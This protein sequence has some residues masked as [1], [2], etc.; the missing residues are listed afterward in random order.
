LKMILLAFLIYFLPMCHSHGRLMTPISRVGH[1]NY[2]NDPTGSSSNGGNN[3]DAWVCRHENPV[4]PTVAYDAGSTITLT[5]FFGAK[6]VGD[7]DV[8]LSYDF[9]QPRG[10][11][12]WFKVANFYDCK[13]NS[14]QQPMTLTLPSWL[15]SGKATLR[16]GWYAVHVFPSVEFYSQCVDVVI[17]GSTTT[18]PSD[19]VLYPLIGTNPVFPLNGNDAAYP[20]RFGDGD[21]MVGPACAKGL[22]ALNSCSLT[23]AGSRGYIDVSAIGCTNC[24]T[25]TSADGTE[26]VP[27][28]DSSDPVTPTDDTTTIG[29]RCGT[30]WNDANGKCGTP[31]ADVDLPCPE[32]E[33][34][35]AD[36]ETYCEDSYPVTEEDANPLSDCS[37]WIN[38]ADVAASVPATWCSET[39]SSEA[40]SEYCDQDLC[41]CDSSGV[42]HIPYF[43]GLILSLGYIF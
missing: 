8:Y 19:V 1:Q 39:C 34:C 16:W 6:H 25:V 15:P 21:F 18:I 33:S 20:N 43:L 3:N 27:V 9:D 35:Y 38:K 4:E 42:S 29:N 32:G 26:V 30:S 28:P 24:G 17:V 12:K 37:E 14:D 11:M 2:E 7:C 23:A 40:L 22:D 31:C 5:W 13:S 41:Q 36:M 10:D